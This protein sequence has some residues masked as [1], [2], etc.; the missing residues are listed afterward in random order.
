M[1]LGYGLKTKGGQKT[2]NPHARD[3]FQ[4]AKKIGRPKQ[5]WIWD[6]PEREEETDDRKGH[7]GK[8]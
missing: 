7:W 1:A 3:E 6:E 8:A 2:L 5:V 4:A